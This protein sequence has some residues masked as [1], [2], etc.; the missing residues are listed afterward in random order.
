MCLFT[1]GS[2]AP[3]QKLHCGP[4]WLKVPSRA[5]PRITAKNYKPSMNEENDLKIF[6]H[7]LNRP[8]VK[9]VKCQHRLTVIKIL[10]CTVREFRSRY[11]GV[12]KVLLTVQ[13]LTCMEGPVKGKVLTCMERPV[14]NQ[15]TNVYGRPC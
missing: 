5:L 4:C 2:R 1:K 12:W 6:F 14:N 7:A 13:V 15:G 11:S 10:E 9:E 3:V 8:S